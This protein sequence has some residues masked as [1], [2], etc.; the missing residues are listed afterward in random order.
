MDD[1]EL[2]DYADKE[3]FHSATL[4]GDLCPMTKFLLDMPDWKGSIKEGFLKA[5]ALDALPFPTHGS[6]SD[7]I[8]IHEAIQLSSVN[9]TAPL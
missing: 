6:P 9:S 3:P 1:M 4:T 5:R 2:L 7:G 8:R